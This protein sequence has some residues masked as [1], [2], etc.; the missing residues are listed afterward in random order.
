MAYTREREQ[1]GLIQATCVGEENKNFDMGQVDD[2]R[3]IISISAG[4]TT[5]TSS[6]DGMSDVSFWV[7]VRTW[8]FASLWSLMFSSTMIL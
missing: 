5:L 7:T 2:T 8:A 4:Q 1:L 6:L 3:S